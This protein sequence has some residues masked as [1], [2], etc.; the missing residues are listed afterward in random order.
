MNQMAAARNGRTTSLMT[1]VAQNEDVPVE[2]LRTEVADGRVVLIPGR[3]SARSLALGSLVRSKVL[4]NLGTS[5][6]SPSVEAEI[7]K[8]RLAAAR[9][10]SIICDQSVG[11]DVAK[12]RAGLLAASPLPLAAVPLYQNAERARRAHGNPL[13]FSAT[14]T[15]TVFAEQ[16]IQGITAPAFHTMTKGLRDRVR[17]SRRVMPLVSRGGALL[18][19]WIDQTGEENPYIERFQDVLGLCVEHD[20][21]LTLVCACR[22]GCV[23]D[24]F[25]SLQEAELEVLA[26]LIRE[27]HKRCVGVIVDGLGHM[28]MDQIPKAVEHYKRFCNGVPLGVM[29]PATTDRGLGHEH[30]VNAIGTAVAVQFGANYCN[31]CARTEHVGL[32]EVSDIPDAIGAAVIATYVG[33]LARGKFRDLDLRMATARSQNAWGLQLDLALD[34]IAAHDTFKRVGSNNKH[35]EG[36]SICGDLCPF[37]VHSFVTSDPG[38][39]RPQ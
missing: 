31:A 10:A 13:A 39:P 36:C 22:S 18:A 2:K 14:E 9:G 35:G 8:A 32:P 21:P 15:I 11:P 26:G 1:D 29:G 12:H 5:V 6:V 23:E 3:N 38:S 16:I 33:D 27:A 25:D 30:V 24:G 28:T 4:C 34:T 19:S 20:V 37:T 17:K 7:S